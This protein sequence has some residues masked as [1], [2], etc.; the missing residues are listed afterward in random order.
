MTVEDSEH[1]LH[2]TVS[3]GSDTRTRPRDRGIAAAARHLAKDIG[4][5][6]PGSQGE[7]SA[8]RFIERELSA[9]DLS[10]ETTQFRAPA[11]TA[12][13][14]VIVHL[15]MVVGV[16][17]FPAN[18][19]ISFVL[20]CLAFF[21][22]LLESF[23]RSPFTWLQ[24]HRN[25]QNVVARVKPRSEPLRTVILIAHMDSP[26]T[27]FYFRPGLVRAVPAAFLLDLASMAALFMLFT[28]AYGGY[29]LRMEET[30]VTLSWHLGLFMAI[31]PS[32][33]LVAL[34]FKAAG[35]RATPG[36]NDNASGVAV[37]LGLARVYTRRRP[38]NTDLWIV[39]TGASDAGGVGVKKLMRRYR[40]ELKGA[41]FIVM[42]G[43][44]RGFPVCY[45]REGRLISFRA[46]RK[47]TALSRRI[48]DVH[49][50]YSAGFRRNGLYL[51]EG[52]MLLSRGRKAITLSAREESGYPRFWRWSRDDYSN[53]DPR[54]LRLTLD[55]VV[56]MVDNIDRGDFK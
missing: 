6:P 33:A 12:W 45:K 31:P 10:P 29:L 9:L 2:H 53:I 24:P 15:L 35:G 52:F 32:L 8:A 54:S 1:I 55:F 20:V 51:S 56:A 46:N 48:S 7:R 41:Y 39:S 30:T 25:S 18:S 34:L 40:R 19:H 14:W 50:H 49:A 26:R 21:F 16:I 37:L 47:L 28:L 5:R 13:S 36:G 22:F 17:V 3:G 23:G 43:V 11:T 4:P 44:G 27:A 42:D 38:H